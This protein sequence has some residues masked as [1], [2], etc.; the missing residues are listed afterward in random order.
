MS[1]SL[2]ATQSTDV[3]AANTAL[4]ILRVTCGAMI[5]AHGYNHLLGGGKVAGAASWFASM[6]MKPGILH[7]WLATIGEL[8]GGAL[9]IAGLFTPVAVAA[10]ISE[11]VVALVTAHRKNGFFIFRPGQGWEYV[12]FIA[13][14]ALSLGTL[15]AGSWSLDGS[16]DITWFNG[17]SGFWIALLGGLGS[18]TGL[19]AVFYRPE[20][21]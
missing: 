18:A 21:A 2:I 10:L 20:K 14:T 5:M 1:L 15:G 8:V 4:L 13:L 7:A 11:M 19:L 9:L 17:W 3:D 16:F 6:G 12:A